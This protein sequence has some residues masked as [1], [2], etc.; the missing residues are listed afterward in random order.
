MPIYIKSY[1]F[2]GR[3]WIQ[4]ECDGKTKDWHIKHLLDFIYQKV[5]HSSSGIILDTCGIYENTI[6]IYYK[7]NKVKMLA[8]RK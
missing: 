7:L 6:L 2:K 1:S 8:K 3:D 5:D 4:E